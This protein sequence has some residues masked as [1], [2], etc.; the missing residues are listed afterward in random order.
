MVFHFFAYFIYFLLFI[1]YYRTIKSFH[2]LYW[3][4]IIN[5]DFKTMIIIIVIG[6]TRLRGRSRPGSRD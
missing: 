1:I 3:H 6:L 2:L 5:I 4:Q